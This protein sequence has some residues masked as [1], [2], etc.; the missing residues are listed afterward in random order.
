M[1]WTLGG[2]AREVWRSPTEHPLVFD[3]PRDERRYLA[4]GRDTD[5]LVDPHSHS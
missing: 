2:A 3:D 1:V 4:F 5:R